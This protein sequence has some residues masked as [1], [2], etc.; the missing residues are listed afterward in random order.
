M[1]LGTL[2]ATPKFPNIPVSLQGK[3]E[4]PGVSREVPCSVLKWETV[5][6]SLDATPKVP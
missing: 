2:D 3:T 5:L 4:I 1:L 6:G